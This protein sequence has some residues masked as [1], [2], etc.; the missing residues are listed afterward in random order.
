M[1]CK[2]ATEFEPL[3]IVTVTLA[4]ARSMSTLSVLVGATPV[5]QLPPTSQ[6]PSL[7]DIHVI[8][9]G[10]IAAEIT[11]LSP[12]FVEDICTL[13]TVVFPP[14][15]GPC[16]AF[17][18]CTSWLEI[19]T[20]PAGVAGATAVT[21]TDEV[22]AWTNV[23]VAMAAESCDFC[24]SLI[25]VTDSCVAAAFASNGGAELTEADA[26]SFATATGKILS[27]CA[28]AERGFCATF[29]FSS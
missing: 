9:A 5:L 13:C 27:I 15:G 26:A 29:A 24:A 23:S 7:S 11:V 2:Y 14:L 12:P 1:F 10:A 4:A 17:S 25:G 21:F 6:K 18:D 20:T 16:D 8:V 19:E 28:A 3:R 22:C